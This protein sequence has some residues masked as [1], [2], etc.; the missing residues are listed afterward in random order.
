MLKKR[1]RLR[2]IPKHSACLELKDYMPYIFS[3]VVRSDYQNRSMEAIWKRLI[4]DRSII[5]SPTGRHALWYFLERAA[6]QEGDE[7]LIA[8][9]NY[10]VVVRLLVQK[11][12]KPVFVD[13]EPE[14]LCMDSHDLA[15]KITKRSRMVVVTHMFGN[16]ADQAAIAALCE[17]HGL[18]LFEDCAHAVGTRYQNQQVGQRGDG[19]LFSFEVTKLISSFGGGMLVLSHTLSAGYE[20]PIHR[21]ARLHSMLDTFSRFIVSVLTT[22]RLYGWTL[23]PLIRLALGLAA[24]GHPTLRN[25]IEPS[26]NDSNYHFK[27][28]SR[29]HF[30]PFMKHMYALQLERLEEN[31]GRRRQIIQ[32]IKARLQHIPEIQLLNED[33]HGHSNA[34]Y[35][36]IYV[37]DKDSLAEYLEEHGIFSNPQEYFDCSRLQQ[38]SAFAADCPHSRYASE[39]ILR[40]PSYPS[41]RDDEVS[42]IASV[43]A[44]RFSPAPMHL[45]ASKRIAHTEGHD[46]ANSKPEDTQIAPDRHR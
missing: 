11:G 7:V 35:F 43:I 18:L 30:K 31:I 17:Q 3:R 38:F 21:V 32:R 6:L 26:K 15:R 27:V 41:L 5:P 39:H 13:I 44:S 34:S 36:G 14:T 22:P 8:A 28:D 37:P 9:Y 2:M 16:P 33:M 40:L 45:P 29:A 25:L 10:Y 4:Q 46:Y 12:L 19:A 1:S 24:R 23:H 20:A 42:Y